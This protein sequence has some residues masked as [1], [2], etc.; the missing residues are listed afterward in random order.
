MSSI[1]PHSLQW[2]GGYPWNAELHHH[3]GDKDGLLPTPASGSR[4][5]HAFFAYPY[6]TPP[7]LG[8]ESALPEIQ[9]KSFVTSF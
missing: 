7:K 3:L 1:D 2:L 8:L 9:E 5:R 4:G 6:P